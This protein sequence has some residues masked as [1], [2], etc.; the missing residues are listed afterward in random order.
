MVQSPCRRRRNGLDPQHTRR[1]AHSRSTLDT[2]GN[3]GWF[4][5]NRTCRVRVASWACPTSEKAP[6]LMLSLERSLHKQLIFRSARSRSG[7]RPA[8]DC[9]SLP[10][11]TLY[12]VIYSTKY[13]C[14]RIDSRR[15]H[16]WRCQTLVSKSWA[17]S[18]S[19]PLVY[20]N[21]SDL[22]I[23]LA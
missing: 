12:L 21:S 20:Q 15:R 10:L 23:S 9:W 17:P 3:G 1:S 7:V 22:W 18:P 16:W 13:V 4:S 2:R 5:P 8:I 19:Q 11:F 6:Y 14:N